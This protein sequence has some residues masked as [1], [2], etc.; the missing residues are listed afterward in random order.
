MRDW[1]AGGEQMRRLVASHDWSETPLGPRDRWPVSLRTVVDL[2]LDSR[3][4]MALMWGRELVLL[5]ND[6]Y[7]EIAEERHP[8]ALGRPTREVWPEIWPV[9]EPLLA[10]V[11]DRGE[12]V[13]VEDELFPLHRRGQLEDAYFTL[14]Y[15]PVR[16]ED[17]AIGGA[18]VL[19]QE[20]TARIAQQ[21]ALE[22]ERERALDVFEHGEACCVLDADFRIVLVNR[23]QERLSRTRRE[24]TLGR[25]FW[26][27]FPEAAD[28]RNK[29]WSEYHRAM[30][31]RVTVELEDH[32][33]PLDLWTDVRIYPTRE[34]GI[35]VFFHD[36]TERKRAEAQREHHRELL[37]RIVERIPVIITIHEPD[38]RTFQINEEYRRVLGWG[39]DDARRGD[40]MERCFPDPDVHEEARRFMEAAES[41]WRELVVTTKDGRRVP[42]AWANIRLSD[43]TQVGIGLDLR[44]RKA[45]EQALRDSEERMRSFLAMLSHELRNPLAPI[46]NSVHILERAA[47]GS[48]PAQRALA[49][50]ARQAGHMTR[51]I[52]DLLDVTR[53]ANGKITLRCERVELNRLAR[54]AADDHR[55]VFAR[56]GVELVVEEAGEP[57]YVN[58]DPTRLAQ[59][60]GNLLSNAVKFTPRGGRTTLSLQRGEGGEAI[61]RVRDDGTGIAPDVLDRIFEPFM[62][63]ETT[64]DRSRG[65]LGL[66]LSL[67]KSLVE[68]HGGTVTAESRGP[69][70]G[71]VFTLRLPA[72]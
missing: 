14:C 53:I 71:A 31:D 22:S 5:Y 11:L 61:V 4:P 21:R 51:L 58:G 49:V 47:P 33:V 38:L 15:S 18:L 50:I 17:G 10:A 20:T 46:R 62:Q 1:L 30:R 40:L 52:D 48:E 9:I 34:G 57:L 29:Y 3:F 16:V 44:E 13:Y 2:V 27:V 7:R 24:D 8:V 66:G 54:G 55:E 42:T 64:M 70:E 37:A 41:G 32:Y 26:D 45:T 25:V 68:M 28:P 63:V 67:V 12:T 60:I 72:G 65:G 39:E 23:E 6:D 56:S 59:V 69:G 19:L 36:A 35:A 43:D